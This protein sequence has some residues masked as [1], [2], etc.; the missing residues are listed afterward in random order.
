MNGARLFLTVLSDRTR[1][2]EHRCKHRKFHMTTGKTFFTLRVTESWNKC[3]PVL[4]TLGTWLVNFHQIGK[5]TL[6]LW[7]KKHEKNININNWHLQRCAELK[8]SSS[9]IRYLAGA[10]LSFLTAVMQIGCSESNASCIFLW[11]EQ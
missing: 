8:I 3:L 9:I 7:Q 6:T 10:V 5:N 11:K 2:S 1:G 4:S